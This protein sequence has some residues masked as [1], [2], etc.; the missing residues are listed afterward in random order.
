M[1]MVMAV[2][3]SSNAEDVLDALINRGYTAT[4]ANT[5]G[6]MLRQSQFSLF[7]AVSKEKLDE[8][9]EI[10]KR[11]CRTQV[12]MS[13]LDSQDEDMMGMPPVVADLGGAITFVWDINRIETF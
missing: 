3:P 11:S 7:I 6:G 2:V 4:Y 5:K 13:T 1:K 9:L 10:I 8:V 12:E